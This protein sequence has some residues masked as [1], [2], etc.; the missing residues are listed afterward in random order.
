[1]SNRSSAFLPLSGLWT[2]LAISYYIE[3]QLLTDLFST[4]A[5]NLLIWWPSGPEVFLYPKAC[6]QKIFRVDFKNIFRSKFLS[7]YQSSVCVIRINCWRVKWVHRYRAI[8]VYSLPKV[9]HRIWSGT[10]MW[11]FVVLLAKPI[12]SN[13]ILIQNLLQATQIVKHSWL[14]VHAHLVSHVTHSLWLIA[15]NHIIY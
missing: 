12:V 14:V 6:Y 4:M 13:Q 3:A 1:M 15:M 7:S 10:K 11:I 2:F 5:R 8:C 9:V